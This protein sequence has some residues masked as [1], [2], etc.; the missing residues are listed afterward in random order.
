MLHLKGP[1][2]VV[3][4][5]LGI[6][7]L[8]QGGGVVGSGAAGVGG[9]RGR[10]GWVGRPG[11]GTSGTQSLD[12]GAGVARR[13]FRVPLGLGRRRGWLAGFSGVD[14]RRPV[15]TFGPGDR[16]ATLSQC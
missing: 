13:S 4:A 11:Q 15:G 9:G 14:D 16:D 8:A 10:L 6:V 12:D 5:S 7:G 1:A 3:L 2:T